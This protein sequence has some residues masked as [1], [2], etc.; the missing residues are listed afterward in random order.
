MSGEPTPDAPQPVDT[1]APEPAPQPISEAAPEPTTPEG[2]RAI[3]AKVFDSRE[4]QNGRGPRGPDGK[5]TGKAAPDGAPATPIPDQAQTKVP[6]PA[7]PVTEAP[8]SWSAEAKAL[9]GSLSPDAQKYIA[10]R[11]G[12]AHKTLTSQGE[13][14]KG[15]DNLNRVL[16]PKAEALTR[17]YGS[18]DKGLET[19]LSLAE[20]AWSD[21]P[22]FVAEQTRLRNITPE[23]LFA[24]FGQ[25][26]AHDPNTAALNSRIQQLEQRLAQ[27]DAAQNT[28][29]QS[30][31]FRAI[32]D[33]KSKPEYKH[34]DRLAQDMGRLMQLDPS[35]DLPAAYDRAA[36]ANP[37]TRALMSVAQAEADKA[38]AEAEAAKRAADAKRASVVNIRTGAPAQGAA[39]TRTMRQSLEAGY[40]RVNAAS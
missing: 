16:G 37:E 21:W 34:F 4:A 13:R 24:A 30:E 29:S 28:A 35:L 18:V 27:Q 10:Q 32:N 22:S 40:D 14:L 9:W 2:R 33:F 12:D 6:S 17:G 8:Q 20:R 26:P 39:P 31:A 36:W 5:F 23:Q 38:K 25:Q 1:P 19:I 11:E 7:A 15:Y 3:M